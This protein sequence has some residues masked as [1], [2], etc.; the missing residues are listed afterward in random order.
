[1]RDIS[2]ELQERAN[3]FAEQI[4]AHEAQF[5]KLIDQ[6]KREHD[7]RREDLK[8]ELEVVN[9]LL[10][11]ELR[12]FSSAPAAPTVQTPEAVHQA[13]HQPA[14]QSAPQTPQHLA[15]QPV[16]DNSHRPQFQPQTQPE[17]PL[18]DFLV[19]RLNEAGVLSR[20][21]LRRLALK[22]GYFADADTAERD[23]HNTLLNVVQAGLIR[24]LPNGDFAPANIRLRRAM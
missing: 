10:D 12:W 1:M 21:D 3:L 24:Q 9:R 8:T 16:Q 2:G 6:L 4:N 23:M 18:A 7:Q 5:A 15:H 17:Q 14:Q 20:D 11:L 22:E 13:V 19:S